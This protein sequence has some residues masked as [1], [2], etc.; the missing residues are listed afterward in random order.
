MRGLEPG[1]HDDVRGRRA[2]VM[3]CLRIGLMDCRDKPGND[4]AMKHRPLPA[5]QGGRPEAAS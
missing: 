2:H 1:I 4:S 3:L 5:E